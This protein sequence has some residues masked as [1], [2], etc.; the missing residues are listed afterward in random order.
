MTSVIEETGATGAAPLPLPAV[1]ASMATRFA[2]TFGR[3]ATAVSLERVDS[4]AAAA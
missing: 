2:E 1:R 3:T 4:A